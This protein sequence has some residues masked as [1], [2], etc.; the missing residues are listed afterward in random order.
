MVSS[1][2]NPEKKPSSA[3]FDDEYGARYGCA[4]LPE[5]QSLNQKSVRVTYL[6]ITL[7]CD[8]RC[9]VMARNA[10]AGHIFDCENCYVTKET[11]PTQ[12]QPDCH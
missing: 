11:R 4:I 10:L 2:R 9:K 12:P 1:C 8:N 5:K 6:K 3:N 7:I